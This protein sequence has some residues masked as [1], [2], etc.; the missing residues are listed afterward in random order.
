MMFV[1][2]P[3]MKSSECDVKRSVLGYLARYSSSQTQ[4]PKSRWF[5]GSSNSSNIGS[6]NSACARA[7]R[8]RQ[9][10]DMSLVC[11]SIICWLNPRPCSSSQARASNVSGSILSSLSLMPASR[12]AFFS[13]SS[14]NSCWL[15]CSSLS[16]SLATTSTTA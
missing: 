6:T 16:C 12:S 10:P 14:S 1:Q 13:G 8:M 3:F 15:N 2:T 5:V 9:P 7:T 11:L 4:A